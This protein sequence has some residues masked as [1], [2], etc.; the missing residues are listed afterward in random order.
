MELDLAREIE[1]TRQEFRARWREEG[2]DMQEYREPEFIGI[3]W[4]T[5]FAIIT[6]EAFRKLSRSQLNKLTGGKPYEKR[7]PIHRRQ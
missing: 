6:A 5:G 4:E 2:N 1:I 7:N 3:R